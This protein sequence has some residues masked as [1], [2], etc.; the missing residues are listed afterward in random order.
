MTTL[1]EMIK[2]IK[3]ENPNGLRIGDD[4]QG[5]QA[6][7][8]AENEATILE[9][10]K[11]RLEKHAKLAEKESILQAKKEAIIRL[12]ELGIDPKAFALELPETTSTHPGDE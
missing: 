5:Y 8:D 1:N 12:T 2:T 11:A 3:A 9:W 4:E 10:A 7:S 6:L